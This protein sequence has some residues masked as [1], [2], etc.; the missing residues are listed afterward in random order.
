MNQNGRKISRKDAQLYMNNY[1][2]VIKKVKE[3]VLPKLPEPGFEDVKYFFKEGY[4]GFVFDKELV[5]RFFETGGADC[6]VVLL[7]ARMRDGAPSGTPN[8]ELPT[9]VLVGCKKD[10]EKFKS[11]LKDDEVASEHPPYDV[12]PDLPLVEGGG[13]TFTIKK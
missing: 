7:G 4:N 2:K 8:Q 1:K 6:L 12:Y 10:G 3:E 5:T 9:I 11:V 13:F